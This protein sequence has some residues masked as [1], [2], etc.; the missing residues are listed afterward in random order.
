MGPLRRAARAASSLLLAR[1]QF[2]AVE[3]TQSGADALHWLLWA[4][5]ATA[6]LAL[7]LIVAT[8]TIVAVAWDRLGWYSLGVLTLI[9][10]IATG[11]LF[12]RLRRALQARPPLLAQTLAELARDREAVFGPGPGAGPQPKP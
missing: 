7:T 3:L 2:A 1:A 10:A 4:L 9:Y 6:L 8:V 12:Y 5:S 11:Y